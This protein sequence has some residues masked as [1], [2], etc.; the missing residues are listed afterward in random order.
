MTDDERKAMEWLDLFTPG[1]TEAH[2]HARTLKAMLSR[3]VLPEDPT[4]G[5]LGAIGEVLRG[6][7]YADRNRVAYEAYRA[8]YA[9]L[10][11]PKTKTVWRVTEA[12]DGGRSPEHF[13]FDSI[14][15]PLARVRVCAERHRI[16]VTIDP[17]EVP[18]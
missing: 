14:D 9:H 6:H 11:A 5:E 18:A 12:Q 17:R 7:I 13:D 16:T 8:L 3:P 2:P 4:P 15:L 1:G 10:S